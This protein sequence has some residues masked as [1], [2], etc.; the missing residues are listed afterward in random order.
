MNLK[1]IKAI[2]KECIFE[3][4]NESNVIKMCA[5]CQKEYHLDD[6]VK[7]LNVSHGICPRHF[8][9][10]MNNMGISKFTEKELLEK[11]PESASLDLSKP[12]NLELKKQELIAAKKS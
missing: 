8:L 11:H 2:I 7:G 12:E 1:K 5:D 10:T 3:V 9:E 4:L 6:M